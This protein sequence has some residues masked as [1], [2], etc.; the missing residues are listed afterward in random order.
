M[1]ENRPQPARLGRRHR[2]PHRAQQAGLRQP[3]RTRDLGP[4]VATVGGFENAAACATA[5]QQPRLPP[6]L[7]EGD[8]HD[9]RV[10]RIHDHVRDTSAVVAEQDVL[11]RL[12]TIGGAI[13]AA[14]LIRAEHMPQRA[15]EHDVGVGGVDTHARDVLRLLEP[16][17][18]PRLAGIEALPH[19]FT[20]R[21]VAANGCF[22]PAHPHHI[23][24]G[25]LHGNR[26]D[27]ATEILVG[28]RHCRL[29]TVGGFPD[30]ATGG[31]HVVLIGALGGASHG[32]HTTRLVGADVAPG[33]TE[34]GVGAAGLR[35]AAGAALRCGGQ[36]TGG[37]ETAGSEDVSGGKD[38]EWAV[39]GGGMTDSCNKETALGVG[40]LR[41]LGCWF[42]VVGFGYWV[43]GSHSALRTSTQNSELTENRGNGRLLG[44]RRW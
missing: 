24:V 22:P 21:H 31:A 30:A 23:G 18:R 13:D 2:N 7:P 26:P 40:A 3:L 29:A 15:H 34:G 32:N 4:R 37:E 28:H 8:V 36:G 5:H 33:D 12:A 19:A 6:G 44:R 20:M 11:P 9:L 14:F 1:F 17:V 16:H 38:H 42:G 35:R 39:G 41:A 43:V 27:R 25:G 10:R